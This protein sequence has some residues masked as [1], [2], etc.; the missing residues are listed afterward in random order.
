MEVRFWFLTLTP[1]LALLSYAILLAIVIQRGRRS[2]LYHF[3][4]FYLLAM[5]VWSFGSA[6]MRLDPSRILLWNKVL[7]GGAVAM[8]LAFFGFVQ[9]FLDERRDRWLWIGFAILL[10]LETTT[11]LG[12]MVTHARLLKGGLLDVD[13]G[14]AIFANAAYWT[15]FVGFAAW[16]LV[17]A[18]RRTQDSVLRNRIRYSLLGVFLVLL[19][20]STNTVPALG[21][22]PI[23]H[24]ANLLNAFLLAYAILRYQ[25]LDIRLVVRKGLF[26]SIPIIIIG[27]GYFLIVFLAVNLFHIVTGYQVLLLSL[28][29]AAVTAMAVQPLRDRVRAWLDRLF[30]REKYSSSLMLQRLSR[31]VASSV[32]DLDRLTNMILD[33]VTTTM[34]IERAAFFLKQGKSGEFCL[35]ARRGLDPNADFRLRQDHPIVHWLSRHEHVLT[36]HDIDMTPQFKALWRQEWEDLERIGTELFIPLKAR[37]EFV[38][39]FAVG[40]KLSEETY[41]QDDQL[42]LI[43]LANQTAVAI[44]N[45]RLYDAERQRAAELDAFAHTVAHDLQN[46][47]GLVIGFA[48]ALEEDH[49]TMPDEELSHYLHTIARSVRRVSSIVDELLLLSELPKME[50]QARPL[51]M[52]HI[53]AEA[54]RR[55]THMIEEYQA[56]IVVPETWPVALGYG[57]W[58]EGVWVNYLSN[59]IKYGGQPPRVELGATVQPDGMVRFWVRDNG[60]GLAPEEQ[61]Q[62]FTPFTRLDQVRTE[63]HGLG[64]SIA[65]RIVEKLDGQ[66]GVESE[67]GRGSTFSFTLPGVVTRYQQFPV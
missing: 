31:T 16:S 66:V 38:A 49:A 59:A 14:P 52:A 33:E 55:L 7:T 18:Y 9:A 56:E 41:S 20:G 42:T 50:V 63:G 60:P 39:I 26:Y 34:H 53:V 58:V 15:F 36:R 24:A 29:L 25:L 40:P 57:P 3:F 17:R 37:G 10:G 35:T 61:A 65:R 11:A 32:L 1:L 48:E 54:Q 23:D 47:L 67:V 28:I 21:A 43:T 64:L 13:T 2:P 8:P 4:A 27:T 5:S 30:F 62:L 45:A 22:L 46:P 6:M 12:L 44:E 51:D 19:G